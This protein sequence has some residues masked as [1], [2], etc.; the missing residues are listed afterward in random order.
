MMLNAKIEASR[1]SLLVEYIYIYIYIWNCGPK[2]ILL[3]ENEKK[4]YVFQHFGC[5]MEQI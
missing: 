5:I 4:V 3:E 1:F 2:F